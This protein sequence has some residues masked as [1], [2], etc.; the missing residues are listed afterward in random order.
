MRNNDEFPDIWKNSGGLAD[1]YRI[2]LHNLNYS[3]NGWKHIDPSIPYDEE[4]EMMLKFTGESY[5]ELVKFVNGVEVPYE[6]FS[7]FSNS[8]QQGLTIETAIRT[9]N[10]GE[11]NARVLSCMRS[12]DINTPG[13]AISYDTLALGTDSQVN[14]LDFMEDEW[15]HVTFVVDN[16]I[17]DEK[18]VGQDN[19]EDMNPVKTIRIYINGV[20]C[21]CNAVK[22]DKFL[23][24]S[25]K[26]YPMVLNCCR[27]IDT[28]GNISFES[29]GECEIKFIRIYNSYL[30]SSEVL[31]NYIAHI[32][33]Q[34]KQ[35]AM[36]DRND[37]TKA[38]LPTI[39]FKRNLASSNKSTFGIL[40]SITDKKMSKKTC[41]DCTME[42]DDGE[43][44][45]IVYDNVD[46]YLQGTSSLQYPVKNYKIKCFSDVER[47]VKNKIVPPSELSKNWTPDNT[48]TLK[49]D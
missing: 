32:Y 2:K 36:V 7:V 26:A 13:V 39:V 31:N 24:A 22:S 46:V 25:N 5:G 42:F 38:S 1:T 3:S 29:F 45:I 47:T 43:G 17:R 12:N 15:V 34:E 9:R 4:G 11:L 37:V 35:Q 19:I 6:P 21:S 49:C 8:G 14:T 40:N 18:N 33:E 20:L 27:M 23:D 48:Y 10:I 44:N 41:V 30:R 16:N 28:A